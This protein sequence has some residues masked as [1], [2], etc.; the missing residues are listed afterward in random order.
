MDQLDQTTA[1]QYSEYL[2][3]RS[4]YTGFPVDKAALKT[5][6]SAF[7]I[8]EFVKDRI[9]NLDKPA[10]L[11]SGGMDSAIMVPHLPKGA[12][13]YTTYHEGD[14]RFEVDLAKNY[15]DRFQ[16]EHRVIEI[17]AKDYLNTIDKL[18]TNKKMPLSP[19]E[20]IFYLAAKK[21][22][23]DGYYDVIT[24]GAADAR[25]GGFRNLRKN[26]SL[27][28]FEQ[29]LNKNYLNPRKILKQ[30]LSIKYLLDEYRLDKKNFFGNYTVDTDKFLRE[31]GLERFAYDNAISSGG[32]RHIAPLADFIF[33]FDKAKNHKKP[34]YVIEEIFQSIYGQRP[35]KKLGI[36]KP[37]SLLSDYKP[38]SYIFRKLNWTKLKYPQKFLVYS[39]DRFHLLKTKTSN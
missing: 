9:S 35:P 27:N 6:K 33:N 30:G 15:C 28:S 10:L 11:L 16:I 37:I 23:E 2:S 1:R 18:M 39:L 32:C 22:S 29:K 31:V 36:H 34:K 38:E 19:A 20:P 14:E 26:R 8:N 5:L 12:V 13:A 7:E 3:F 25:L 24:G 17:Q 4:F 21:A